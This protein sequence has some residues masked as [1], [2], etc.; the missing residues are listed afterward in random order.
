MPYAHITIK[1]DGSVNVDRISGG[2]YE[3]KVF[4]DDKIVAVGDGRFIFEIPQDIGGLRLIKVEAWVTTVGT[5]GTA[6]I[7]IRNV[8]Q[9]VD[10]LSTRINID[11]NKKNSK[12]AT[13]Q[14]V[15]NTAN[16]DVVWG[17]HIAVDVD[18][19]TSGSKGLGVNLTFG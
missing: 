11:L 15:I 14:P 5:S 2:L 13:T 19:V 6:L 16:D 7:Q 3:I 9:A 17:D 10:M 8:T 1:P 12:D 18:A 4:A